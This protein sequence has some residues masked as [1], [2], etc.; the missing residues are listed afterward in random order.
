MLPS[1]T[2]LQ[3]KKERLEPQRNRRERGKDEKKRVKSTG[4]IQN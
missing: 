1:A 2:T 3:L 4:K